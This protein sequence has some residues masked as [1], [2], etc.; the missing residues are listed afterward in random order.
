MSTH[1]IRNTVNS[2]ILQDRSVTCA[3]SHK[4]VLEHQYDHMTGLQEQICG[5][6][7]TLQWTMFIIATELTNYLSAC[8]GWPTHCASHRVGLMG[9]NLS[10]KNLRVGTRGFCVQTK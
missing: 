1:V 3:Y 10:S 7:V 6:R 5:S 4:N 8:G 9:K 2:L